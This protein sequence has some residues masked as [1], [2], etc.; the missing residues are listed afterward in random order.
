MLGKTYYTASFGTHGPCTGLSILLRAFHARG[1][2][3]GLITTHLSLLG[4]NGESGVYC[5]VRTGPSHSPAQSIC[6]PI[7]YSF[8]FCLLG[9]VKSRACTTHRHALT[10]TVT[11]ISKRQS[12]LIGQVQFPRQVGNGSNLGITRDRHALVQPLLMVSVSADRRF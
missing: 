11:S 5:K 8:K 4:K 12:A 2:S 1:L 9:T 3:L 6:L 10:L 7:V